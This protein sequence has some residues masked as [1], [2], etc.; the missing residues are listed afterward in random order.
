MPKSNKI[1]IAV[2]IAAA[3]APAL[4]YIGVRLRGVY[5]LLFDILKH[6]LKILNF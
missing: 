5:L 6:A 2:L 4:Y 1:L 3:A